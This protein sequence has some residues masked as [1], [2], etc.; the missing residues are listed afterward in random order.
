[1]SMG[2][3]TPLALLDAP[4]SGRMAVAEAITNIAAA[5]VASLAD[6]RLSANWMAACGEPG[7]DADLYATVQAIGEEFC[8]ALGITIPVG[9]DSLSMKTGWSEAG[10]ARKMVAPLSLI[11]S[12]FA[13]VRDVRRTL[14]PQLRTDQGDTSLWLIDLG[15]GR[16]RLGASCLAQVYGK[17]GR[18][19]PDCE[20]PQRLA[21]F[22]A[23]MAQLRASGLIL[24]Y[25]DRSDGGVFATLAE[26]AFAGHCGVEVELDAGEAGA[27]AALFNEELGA[28]LQLRQRDV[29][30]VREVLE[31]HGLG[32]LTHRIGTLN[33]DDRVRIRVAG[34]LALDESRVALHHA[35]SQTSFKM[36]E[37][38]DNPQCARE[39]YQSIADAGDPGLN[40]RLTFDPSSKPSVAAPYIASG[41]RPKVAI[42]REQGVNSHV[43][44][45][46]AFHRAGFS[47]FDVH[48]TDL[49]SG[50]LRL[51][52][53]RGLVVCGGFSYGDVLGA[54]EG[55]AKS[56]LFHARLREDFTRFFQRP[57][58]FALGVCNGCQ[59]MSALR[60]LI[61]GTQHWPRFVRN[62]S[63]QFEG[64]F[65]LVEIVES[66]SLF[67]SGMQGS[68]MPIVVSHG[69]GRAQFERTGDLQA[70][71]AANLLSMRFV[72]NHGHPAQRYPANPNGSPEGLTGI[73]TPDG[74]VTLLM[75]HPDRVFRTVQNSWHPDDWSEDSPWMRMFHNARAWV[76]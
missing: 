63:E 48:M 72:D 60:E 57:E 75:P 74:R 13:P 22:F 73:T 8:P 9:K 26:M 53:F 61:P 66:P 68:R 62:R 2:A 56:I 19:A 69:E 5:D 50:R 7:E 15:A 28:V 37:L 17:L 43:E 6:V 3:R 4:A 36:M 24:A 14:T 58:T 42:L 32:G 45:A 18:E 65:S 47:P 35:W 31:T 30:R 51:D 27:A 20:D 34:V 59:M 71:L 54:G 16:H 33:A 49:V 29:Q 11:I 1:M 67:F 39:Q 44:M 38:R 52:E 46:A 70:L 55:W 40:V 10:I 64:R 25:H 41:V 12:A 21:N 76:G 23:A